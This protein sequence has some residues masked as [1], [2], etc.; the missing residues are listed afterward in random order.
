M[1][2]L[3]LPV[4][5]LKSAPPPLAVLASPVL[6]VSA[7]SPVPVFS[8]AGCVGMQRMKTECRVAKAGCETEERI[9]AF[10]RGVVGIASVRCWQDRPGRRGKRK[11]GE[12]E[13]YE[14]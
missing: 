5:L 7:L 12:R 2:T 10:S 4:V 14:K 9:F 1:A 13:R 3:E 11:A 8:V 6:F